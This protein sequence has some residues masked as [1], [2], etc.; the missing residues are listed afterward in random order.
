MT[1]TSPASAQSFL[2]LPDRRT[3]TGGGWRNLFLGALLILAV[4]SIGVIFLEFSVRDK[5]AE[6]LRNAEV[7]LKLTADGRAQVLEEWLAGRM[8]RAEPIVH[9]DLFALF[10]AEVDQH[11]ADSVERG[12][13][14]DQVPYM[15]AALAEF[16]R[17]ADLA[18]AYLVA[19]DGRAFLTSPEAPAL[20]DSVREA[21]QALF[22]VGKATVLSLAATAEGLRLDLLLPLNPPQAANAA[23]AGR[24][25][26]VLVMSLLADARLKEVLSPNPLGG[27]GERIA[28][29]QA[30]GGPV[31]LV[32]P[33]ETPALQPLS[34]DW[35]RQ[36]ATIDFA[37]RTLAG[38]SEAAFSAG[39]AVPE[40]PWMVLAQAPRAVVLDPLRTHRW[41][42]LVIVA[43]VTIGV[44][45]AALAFWWRQGSE[46]NRLLAQQFRA[47][48]SRLQTQRQLLDS[49]N[50]SIAEHISVKDRDGVYIF[51]NPAFAAAVGLPPQSV[52]G[53]KDEN[54]F[55]TGIARITAELD[56]QVLQHDRPVER[57]ILLEIAGRLRYLQ[58]SKSPFLD[59]EGATIGVVSVARD[60]TE[61]ME[62]QQRRNQAVM[63]TIRALSNTV[64]AVD[65][66][67]SGHS[68]KLER[69]SSALARRLGCSDSEVQTLQIA[70]NLSQIGKLSVPTE[71]L[72]KAE[73]LS[74]EEQ[75]VMRQ[76][77]VQAE[78]ILSELDFGLPIRDVLLQMHERLDGS[79]YP[80][81]LTAEDIGLAG[82][83]LAV[84][85]VF[86]ARI[87]PRSYRDAITPESA[88]AV[89]SE[90]TERYDSEVLEA[91]GAL[92]DEADFRRALQDTSS[93][94]DT[95]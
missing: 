47:L 44:G 45:A 63:N 76:H 46:N 48:A 95:A 29:L 41:F 80:N 59:D 2:E 85:D 51:V 21:A 52:L 57:S 16:A 49:I 86:C 33:G 88:H 22:P 10:A 27:P 34:G 11:A 89:L 79:G 54:L 71:I 53:R 67:L 13:L 39:V 5:E 38:G 58:V 61:L 12:P 3:Y 43:L 32:A 82:R 14:A 66:Y 87:T 68:R 6:L 4:F 84:A 65:P 62:A 15:Q 73:R 17:Q 75:T 36:P 92:L 90:N 72:T 60:I 9:S 35:P 69:V 23:D 78:N 26:G 20:S 25:V 91:L 31:T 1:S 70:A 74:P 30:A 55:D 24:T 94:T 28:L 56:R 93:D 19:K 77:I 64:E 83:I 8:A 7:R 42:G 81:G 40:A 18:G 50:T 37:E